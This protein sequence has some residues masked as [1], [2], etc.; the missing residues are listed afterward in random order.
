MEV[1]VLIRHVFLYLIT[2][3]SDQFLEQQ[4]PKFNF[5]WN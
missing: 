1:V 5:V 3:M 4:I 2:K